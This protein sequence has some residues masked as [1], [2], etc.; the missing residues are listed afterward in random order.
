MHYMHGM[1]DGVLKR[2]GFYPLK[3]NNDHSYSCKS[4]HMIWM[5]NYI[6]INS[7]YSSQSIE[8]RV[9]VELHGPQIK[10]LFHSSTVVGSN[11]MSTNFHLN[12][13]MPYR[14]TK[15]GSKWGS[16]APNFKKMW[17]NVNLCLSTCCLPNFIEIHQNLQNQIFYGPP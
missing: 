10:I 1:G 11:N 14:A 3:N 17:K 9:Q 4:M 8:N 2:G 6:K 5:P 12:R 16:K 7:I 15:M 13:S